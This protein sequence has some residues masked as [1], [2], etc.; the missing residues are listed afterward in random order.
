[1]R[2]L[3]M[4]LLWPA[5]ALASLPPPPA[6]LDLTADELSTLSD[7]DVAIRLEQTDTGG[8]TIGIVDVAATPSQ[9]MDAIMD[10]PPRVNETGALKEVDVSNPVAASG[11]EPEKLDAKFSL[12]VLG[13]SIVFH[14]NYEIDRP[15]LWAVSTLD[16]SKEN[17]M[18]SIY[19]SYQV[20][21]TETGSRIIYRSQSDTGRSVPQ[22]ISRWLANNA[23]KDQLTGIRARAEGT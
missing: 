5:M 17:D 6:L 8:M 16:E 15:G 21:A 23:L 10:L 3:S 9:T 14:L 7:R 2:W 4:M 1:M 13:T 22:W 20:F 12:R 19:A 18:V 11:S